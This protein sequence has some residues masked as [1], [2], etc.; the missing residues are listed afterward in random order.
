[1]RI[2]PL[3][4]IVFIAIKLVADFRSR[5]R[6]QAANR[7][8]FWLNALLGGALS[9][10]LFL[11]LLRYLS[12]RPEMFWYRAASR[13]R[14]ALD[15]TQLASVFW[16]NLQDALLMFNYRGDVVPPNT[17]PGTPE[18]ETVSAALLVLGMAVLLWRLLR[19]REDAA[20]YVLSAFFVLLLPSVLSLAYPEE[21][22]S[23][24]RTGGAVPLVMII[25]ALPLVILYQRF[26]DLPHRAA[27]AIFFLLLGAILIVSLADNYR[28][29]FVDYDQHIR[30]SLWNATEMGEAVRAFTESEGVLNDVF[31]IPYP[32]WVDTRA[33]A[34]ASGDITWQNAVLDLRELAGH[35][36]NPAPKLYLFYPEDEEALTRLSRI[37]PEGEAS[38]YK[39][40]R[41]GK[42]FLLYRV[43]A[44]TP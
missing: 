34:I 4:F 20:A 16:Q 8:A 12:D 38:R 9:L 11:P 32:H 2:V 29:Y 5:R 30:H 39:S 33:I 37:F 44:R 15:T 14:G 43:P 42:D 13:A 41:P 3:L 28:W 26:R 18:L 23:V 10:L 22:P 19:Y 24:V 25:V 6:K 7:R 21:N 36:G 31:H 17:I 27:R 1:M 40:P 35:A